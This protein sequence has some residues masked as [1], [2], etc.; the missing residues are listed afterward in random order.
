[1][2]RITKGLLATVA[3]ATVA[4]GMSACEATNEPGTHADRVIKQQDGTT[5]AP[6][7]EAKPDP[8]AGWTMSQKQ[9]VASAEDYLDTQ[10]F[11]KKGLQDQ[12]SSEYG[13]GFPVK[14]A[15]F[16]VNHIDVDWNKQAAAAAADYLD[17]QS[18]SKSGLIDQLESEYGEQFTHAQAVYGANQAY[19]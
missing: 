16:A 17:T 3:V 7:K 15:I 12:L 4:V 10:S 11:S 18:F 1:M 5:A 2:N 19:M 8:T 14:D 6:A 9:A 13:E